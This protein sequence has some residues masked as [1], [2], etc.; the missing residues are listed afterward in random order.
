[1]RNLILPG[2]LV[3]LAASAAAQAP[4]SGRSSAALQDWRARFGERWSLVPES[5]SGGGA[6]LYGGRAAWPGVPQTDEQ[7]IAR[8]Q[9]ALAAAAD[10]LGVDVGT[11]VPVRVELLPLG[12]I[13]SGDKWSVELRQ[14]LGGLPVHGGSVV[15]LFDAR[16]AL[17]SIQSHAL[18]ALDGLVLEPAFAAADARAQAVQSFEKEQALPAASVSEPKL[19]ILPDESAA[20]ASGRLAWEV[21]VQSSKDLAE[22]VGRRYWV[23]A[24]FGYPLRDEASVHSFDISGTINTH[25]TPGTQ[26]D[27]ATNPETVQPAK[28]LRIQHAGGVVY[29]DVNGNFTIPG[30]VPAQTVTLSYAGLFADVNDAPSGTPYT[31]SVQ[32]NPGPGNVVLLNPG[33]LDTVTSQANIF[34][35]VATVRDY[36]RRITP[37]DATADITFV[38]HAN[39]NSTCNAYY[40]GVS[41][42]FYAAGG[43]CNNT[44]FSTV[45]AH[46]QGHWLNDRYGTGNGSDGMGEGNA[47]V[48][49]LYVFDTPLN[50]EGFFTNGGAVRNGNNTRQ[51]C[52]D[53][54]PGCYGEVHADGEVWMGAAWKVR[55]NLNAALGNTA[56]DLAADELFMGW[57]NG[58]NQTQIRSVIELQWLLLDD[59]DANLQNG[60]PH[61][62]AIKNGFRVQ[63]FP[64]YEI[65]FGAVSSLADSSCEQGSYPVTANVHTLQGTTISS[66]VLRYRVGGGSWL[67]VPMS[68]SG[69]N[70]WTGAIPYLVSPASVEYTVVATDSAGNTKS[71]FCSPRSFLIAQISAFVS[72]DFESAGAWTHG[73]IGDTSNANDDWQQG[74]P[75]GK[76]GTSQ[77]VPWSDP[78]AAALGVACRGNDLGITAS[79]AGNGAYQANVHNYLRSPVYDCTGQSGVRLIFKRWLT[80]EK[81]QYDV[82][83]V[84]VNGTE[85]WRNPF[86]THV[87]DTGWSIQSLDISAVADN[88]PSVTVQFELQSDGG[89]ELGGWQIDDLHLGR[90]QSA[91]QCSAVQSF[92]F[93]DGSLATP[94]PCANF[95]APGHGCGDFFNP[96]GALL[97]GSGSTNPDSVVLAGSGMPATALGVYLQHD[98]LAEHAFHNGVLCGGGHPVRL[99]ARAAVGG[100]SSFP[101]P[102]DGVT[103]S[104]RGGVVPGSG[105]RRYYSLWYRNGAPGFCPPGTANVTNGVMITW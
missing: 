7:W 23:D 44:A 9:A 36:V 103:L 102:G 5:A 22:P 60:T 11:L 84:L 101:Q 48:F 75:Q 61:A 59:D 105:V 91:P 99:W 90:I 83:R 29:T 40:D 76:S 74:V 86:A 46:E 49:A 57:M 8:A 96:Q 66:V 17:L 1:M 52:G 65:E 81:S 93:G 30:A 87:L 68:P 78:A 100:A 82:A 104:A 38:G 43:S 63:G 18:S 53:C 85:V 50:G 21:E 97:A 62:T 71:A 10:V 70:D 3:T 33:P 4:V 95:G 28:Y 24:R 58:F 39:I 56:G 27:S 26:A 34:N 54:S 51:F 45:I 25:A 67:D 77:S 16:G 89:L 31:Q 13:G 47:D 73:T 64:G 19:V 32:L 80:V 94:C 72:D 98:A 35:H 12:L 20:A 14:E 42:N 92:C 41:I 37:S 15:A 88:N 6:L 2:I 69:G 55:A 79:G